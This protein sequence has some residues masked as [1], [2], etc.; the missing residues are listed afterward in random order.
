ML[1]YYNYDIVF[2][3]IP[4]EVTLAVNITNCPH[5][6]VGCHSP[7]LHQN[8]GIELNTAALDRLLDMY[9]KQ[10][11]CV[12]FMGGDRQP[13]DVVALARYLRQ[14]SHL[15]VA[16]YSGNDTLPHNAKLF[17]YVKVGGYQE[18]LGGLRSRTTNQ[19]LYRY[20]NGHSE[21][22]TERFWRK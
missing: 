11:T 7:H 10:I 17:D 21:D 14:H 1:K 2:Q 8:I 5:R 13:K 19:R 4:D 9:G 3:E 16:W 22:I 20:T 12:C 6:C 18:K 15:K